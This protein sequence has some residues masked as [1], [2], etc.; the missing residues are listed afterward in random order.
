[1]TYPIDSYI[2]CYHID[3]EIC[4]EIV[5][6]YDKNTHLA[7]PGKICCTK[8]GKVVET[9]DTKIKK[10]KDI[11]IDSSLMVYP[12]NLYYQLLQKCL[13]KYIET[14]P[15]LNTMLRYAITEP[16]SLQKYEPGEGYFT[17]HIE[18]N[19][20]LVGGARCLVFMTYLN[21]V[22]NGGTEF[23]F[24]NIKTEAKKGSTLIWPAYF[25][26]PHRAAP[27]LQEDKY[28]LTGWLHHP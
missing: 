6:F 17:T 20:S 5:N 24:H 15:I 11:S 28:I 10:S 2:G 3:D 27:D 13:I 26:H 19:G 9:T 21:D 18:N 22:P 25:T 7:G 4:D 16:V 12:F 23:T 1:M 8:N 14:Y